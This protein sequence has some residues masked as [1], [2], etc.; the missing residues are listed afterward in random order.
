MEADGQQ[1]GPWVV[2][3]VP[4]SK[5]TPVVHIQVNKWQ[6]RPGCSYMFRRDVVIDRSNPS[7]DLVNL[8]FTPKITQSF[9]GSDMLWRCCFAQS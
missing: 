9:A 4:H 8:K 5:A 3:I 7:F 6:A 1:W 2:D